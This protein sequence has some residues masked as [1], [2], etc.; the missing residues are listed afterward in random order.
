M[1]IVFIEIRVC[2]VRNRVAFDVVELLFS[3]YFLEDD[4]IDR[5]VKVRSRNL[6]CKL[7]L[8]VINPTLS[9]GTFVFHA[10]LVEVVDH[11]LLVGGESEACQEVDDSYVLDDVKKISLFGVFGNC[12][13]LSFLIFG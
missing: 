4:L 6:F 7:I 10:V 11:L 5:A 3:D 12:V 8:V 2:L 9:F 13:L 1:I